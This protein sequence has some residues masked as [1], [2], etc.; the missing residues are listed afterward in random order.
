MIC[1]RNPGFFG[2]TTLGKS[3]SR[4]PSKATFA[5]KTQKVNVS[6]N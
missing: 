3:E 5:Q 2:F 6:S 4:G 1:I